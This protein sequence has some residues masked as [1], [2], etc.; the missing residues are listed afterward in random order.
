[1]KRLLAAALSA[2]FAVAAH[3]NAPAGAPAPAFAVTDLAGKPVKLEDYKGK[4]IVLE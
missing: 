2:T 1:M 4:S 3:A